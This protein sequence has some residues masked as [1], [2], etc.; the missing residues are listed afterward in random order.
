[1]VYG[2]SRRV[3]CPAQFDSIYYALRAS[4]VLDR[5]SS[6]V[7]RKVFVGTM[8]L[9]VFFG[10]SGLQPDAPETAR[11]RRE[12]ER[13]VPDLPVG[14]MDMGWRGDRRVRG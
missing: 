13:G 10:L 12:R 2:Y 14:F 1:M 4:S 7:V 11:A 5:P 9:L 6:N 8:S 3:E